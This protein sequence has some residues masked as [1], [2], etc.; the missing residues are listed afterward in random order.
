MLL[1]MHWIDQSRRTLPPQ[2][3][4]PERRHRRQRSTSGFLQPD[5]GCLAPL[6]GRWEAELDMHAG[7]YVTDDLRM[8]GTSTIRVGPGG[9]SLVLE[10]S[11]RGWA[12][13]AIEHAVI[14][15]CTHT[16]R[17]QL[18]LNDSFEGRCRMLRG[19]HLSRDTVVFEGP[20]AIGLIAYQT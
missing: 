7:G 15:A 6:I 13:M 9:R 14:D 12:G 4:V 16:G 3:R 19:E 8:Q 18:Y 2:P 5:L 20:A 11:W 17:L 1:D 10:S